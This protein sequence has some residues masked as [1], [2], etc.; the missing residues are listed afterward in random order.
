MR[1]AMIPLT[2]CAWDMR[3]GLAGGTRVLQGRALDARNS[4]NRK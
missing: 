1:N 4:S 2:L 3:V